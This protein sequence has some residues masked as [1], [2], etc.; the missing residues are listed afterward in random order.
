MKLTLLIILDFIAIV[1]I[2]ALLAQQDDQ[3]SKLR[4]TIT[5]HAQNVQGAIAVLKPLHE[6]LPII[7]AGV[8]DDGRTLEA[9][10]RPQESL[11]GKGKQLN[12]DLRK[13]VV[14][15]HEFDQKVAETIQMLEGEAQGKK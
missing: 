12:A 10:A 14:E 11:Q 3:I 15:I 6:S 13:R 1:F 9:L 2:C 7:A 8:E 5:A 4:T